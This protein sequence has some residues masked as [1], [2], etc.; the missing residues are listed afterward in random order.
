MFHR[1]VKIELA[2]DVPGVN[3]FINRERS[4]PDRHVGLQAPARDIVVG[5]EA[6]RRRARKA[7]TRA[8]E[9]GDVQ[10]TVSAP[11]R[12]AGVGLHGGKAVAVTVR[13]APSDAGIRF[14]RTDPAGLGAVIPA[15]WTHVAATPLCTRIADPDSGVTVSTIEHLMAALAGC[16]IHNALIDIDGAEVPILDGSAAPF[17]EGLLV[18]GVRLQD[19]PLRALR[20]LR[21]VELRAG[22]ALA[23]LDPAPTLQIEF[24]IAFE[25]AA[26]GVQSRALDMANGAFVHELCDS[27]T[28]CRLRDV[29]AMRAQGLAL[30]GSFDNAV[31]VDGASVLTPGGMRHPD[32]PVRH[33]MLDALGD[34]ALAGAPI[35]GR[36]TG[37]RAGHALTAGLLARLFAEPDA[38][39]LVTLD[40][41]AMARLPGAGVA[42]RRPRPARREGLRASA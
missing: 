22:A 15:L 16:G 31:V 26:I 18:A 3:T 39:A 11:V 28:F 29:E 6:V 32:E 25:D 30:G 21:P 27:R 41:A 14:R 5:S 20:I 36:Y 12:F 34:L 19:A 37:V 2:P 33:K 24:A 10:T 35:L 17:V 7:V 42:P 8:P 23:R 4:P 40:R 1:V 9:R 38:Y 13:P